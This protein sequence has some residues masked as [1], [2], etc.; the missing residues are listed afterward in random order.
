MY[1]HEGESEAAVVINS[2]IFN[3]RKF[4]ALQMNERLTGEELLEVVPQT[5]LD[6]N[7][8]LHPNL[9]I[10]INKLLAEEIVETKSKVLEIHQNG[11]DYF[12]LGKLS[13]K[14]RKRIYTRLR[15]AESLLQ[16]EH[17]RTC[18]KTALVLSEQSSLQV[19]KRLRSQGQNLVSLGNENFA[20][21]SIGYAL[22]GAVSPYLIYRLRLIDVAGLWNW[23]QDFIKGQDEISKFNTEHNVGFKKPTMSGNILVIFSLVLFGWLLSIL[24]IITEC[25]WIKLLLQVVIIHNTDLQKFKNSGENQSSVL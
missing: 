18:Q 25:N 15:E 20:N 21:I 11:N 2:E 16:L 7:T 14:V 8:K 1:T 22:Q 3:V 17:I 23:W 9:S 13:T 10:V 12:E 4:K 6:L 19:A 24:F 5:E